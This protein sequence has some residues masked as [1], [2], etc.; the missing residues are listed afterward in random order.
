[1][2]S[3]SGILSWPGYYAQ[4]NGARGGEGVAE[5]RRAYEYTL[6]RVGTDIGALAPVQGRL[7]PPVHDPLCSAPETRCRNLCK[8]FSGGLTQH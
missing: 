2:S 8:A 7:A 3:P 5:V 6:D 4:V 1:M